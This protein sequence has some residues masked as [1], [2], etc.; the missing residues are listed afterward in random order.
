MRGTWTS[1]KVTG[2]PSASTL[3]A[4]P[5]PPSRRRGGARRGP[6]TRAAARGRPT[7]ARPPPRVGVLGLQHDLPR[8]ARVADDH[9]T[10]PGNDSR[11]QHV[12]DRHD[13]AVLRV[14]VVEVRLVRGRVAVADRL[15]RHD[16]AVAVL[17]RVDGGRAD[18][19]GG[20]RAGDDDGVAALRGQEASRAACRRRPTRTAS[21]AP[22]RPARGAI[23]GSISTQ[24]AARP[25]ASSSAGIL[26]M[27]DRRR[28][29]GRASS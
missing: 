14:D 26:S 7:P 18:A 1:R 25:R 22:A 9:A 16:G 6:A 3:G 20:R 12:V 15:A 13:V 28:L 21:S 19:A 10:S 23:R 27:N 8:G 5:T 4:A 29:P 17:E 11:A 2:F 24:R